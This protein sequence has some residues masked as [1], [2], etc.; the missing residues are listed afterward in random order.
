MNKVSEWSSLMAFQVNKG[1]LEIIND[2][3]NFIGNKCHAI[4]ITVPADV[5]A[6]LGARTS[7][8]TVM[9]KFRIPKCTE[10]A[11]EMLMTIYF[12]TKDKKSQW[13]NFHKRQFFM[14]AK[15]LTC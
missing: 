2:Q 12:D 8:D 14:A 7:A 13:F 4:V 1:L 15:V 6:P 3:R 10:L 5:L 9:T 11:L